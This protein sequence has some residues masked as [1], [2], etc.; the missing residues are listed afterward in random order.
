[1]KKNKRQREC[2]G[3]SKTHQSVI[4]SKWRITIRCTITLN[5]PFPVFIGHRVEVLHKLRLTT[6]WP[7]TTTNSDTRVPLN[8]NTSLTNLFGVQEFFQCRLKL[9]I[10]F[11]LRYNYTSNF[12][13]FNLLES[14]QVQI[15]RRSATFNIF[16][17]WV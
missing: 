1:M 16:I 14:N 7:H 12:K 2:C 8:F 15:L 17:F 3:I 13:A 11:F 5:V 10:I 9:V 6:S 4:I